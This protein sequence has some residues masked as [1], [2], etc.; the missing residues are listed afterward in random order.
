MFE[1][2][3][4]E[5]REILVLQR[6]A[7]A[8]ERETL[9]LLH[10]ILH[11]LNP[12]TPTHLTFKGDPMNLPDPGQTLVFTGTLTPD[13][14]A[15]PAGTTFSVSSADPNVS[16]SVDATGLIVTA[17]ISTSAVPGTVADISWSTSSFTPEPSTSPSSLSATI[18]L[19]IG[20]PPPPP[21]PTPTAVTF[22]QTT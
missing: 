22:A 2:P 8:L 11:H 7:L 18:P 9:R 16:V 6:E 5:I 10:R 21:T 19:T 13:G 3:L 1:N 20:A 12:A 17:A 4:H 14:S 15:F